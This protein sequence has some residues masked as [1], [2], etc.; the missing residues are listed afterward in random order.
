MKTLHC[1]D[2]GF[3]CN[4]VIQ[5]NNEKEVMEKAAIHARQKHGIEAIDKEMATKIKS[6]IKDSKL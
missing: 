2:A 6:L 1:R 4:H 3:D 5:A